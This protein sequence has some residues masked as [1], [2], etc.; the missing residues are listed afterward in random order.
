M[1]DSVPSGAP[2]SL[3]SIGEPRPTILEE[4]PDVRLELS[5]RL[6]DDVYFVFIILLI[7]ILSKVAR[8]GIETI[9]TIFWFSLVTEVYTFKL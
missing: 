5:L 1:L 4:V 7:L 6:Q 8:Y 3:G 2:V 9:K